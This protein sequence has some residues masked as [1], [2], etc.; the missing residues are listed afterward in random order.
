MKISPFKAELVNQDHTAY[1]CKCNGTDS[2]HKYRTTKSPTNMGSSLCV[3]PKPSLK[4]GILPSA[5][6]CL[7]RQSKAVILPQTD[8]DLPIRNG[9]GPAECH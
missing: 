1:W 5:M 7:K 8:L 9:I 3:R 2:S 6:C 4:E